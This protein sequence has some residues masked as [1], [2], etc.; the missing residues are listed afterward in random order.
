MNRGQH[1]VLRT[2]SDV[3]LTFWSSSISNPIELKIVTK[4]IGEGFPDYR[5]ATFKRRRHALLHH[6]MRT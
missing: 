4:V 5:L 2:Y 6:I 1:Y 3:A